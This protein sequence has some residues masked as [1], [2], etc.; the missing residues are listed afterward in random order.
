MTAM[1]VLLGRAFLNVSGLKVLRESGS[2]RPKICQKLRWSETIGIDSEGPEKPL[3]A[4]VG[5]VRAIF[6]I[7]DQIPLGGPTY[8]PL[9][10]PLGPIGLCL[11]CWWPVEL[12]PY[13]VQGTKNMIWNGT[14]SSK[15]G[16]SSIHVPKIA[17]A[18]PSHGKEDHASIRAS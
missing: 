7:L 12:N 5:L 6:T 13:E 17:A 15:A 2:K 14:Q 11:C 16:F 18:Q 10:P 9:Q 4:L 1:L 3:G 8:P